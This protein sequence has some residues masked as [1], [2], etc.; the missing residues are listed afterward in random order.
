MDQDI[1]PP[2]E[3]VLAPKGQYHLVHLQKGYGWPTY[4]LVDIDKEHYYCLK[5]YKDNMFERLMEQEDIL[6][7]ENIVPPKEIKDGI[8]PNNFDGIDWLQIKKAIIFYNTGNRK[9]S[10]DVANYNMIM[11]QD[12][13]KI[14]PAE[15]EII[16]E[17]KQNEFQFIEI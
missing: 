13:Q 7:I 9:E 15:K 3:I 17:H 8:E 1:F 5:T 4:L 14:L 11:K 12:K 6:K 10:V 2:S 16:E